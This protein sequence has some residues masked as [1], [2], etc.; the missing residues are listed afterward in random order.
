[1]EKPES[2]YYPDLARLSH[3]LVVAFGMPAPKLQGLMSQSSFDSSVMSVAAPWLRLVRRTSLG[4]FLTLAL[5]MGAVGCSDGEESTSTALTDGGVNAAG[6]D[7]GQ[8]RAPTARFKMAPQMLRLSHRMLL[9][10]RT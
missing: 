7:A 5:G 8:M 1:M 3:P 6:A 4:L 9:S 2:F 10:V